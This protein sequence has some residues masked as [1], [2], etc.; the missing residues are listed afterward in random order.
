MDTGNYT[1]QVIFTGNDN[2]NTSA[3]KTTFEVIKTETNFNIIVNDSS[4]T[5]GDPITVTQSLPGDATGSIT[6]YFANGT[7]IKVI[8]VDESFILAGLNAGTYTIY[9]NRMLHMTKMPS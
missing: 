6:Y 1:V 4:I 9:A 2:Y 3:N 5:Y 8:T 7:I